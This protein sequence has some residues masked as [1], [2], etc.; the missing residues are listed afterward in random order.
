MNQPHITFVGAGNMAT[1]LAGGLIQQG[2]AANQITLCDINPEALERAA[3]TLGVLTSQ[4]AQAACAHADVVVIAVKPQV[5]A[6]VVPALKTAI[7]TRNALVISIVAGTPLSRF[8]DWLGSAAVVRCMP[9][10]PALVGLGATGLWANPQVSTE[11]RDLAQRILSAVG[12]AVWL[13]S[14]AQID[15]IT[16]LSGSGPAYYFLVMEAMISAGIALGLPAPI[17]RQMTLQTALGAAQMAIQS[18]VEPDELRRRVTSPGGT[19]QAALERLE[20]GELRKLFADALTAACER[21]REL[22]RS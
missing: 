11:Q 22:A 12:C 5:V 14:E 17:A 10:T 6:S 9:N 16:A 18:D 20:Q 1:S 15:A 3:Q 13:E 21:S 2:T 7:A 19:T 4:D 8:A